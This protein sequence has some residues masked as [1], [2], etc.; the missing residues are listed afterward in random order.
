[1]RPI[2]LVLCGL[3]SA[4]WLLVAAVAHAQES[5][6]APRWT[7]WVT[8]DLGGGTL[9]AAPG[10][11]A[12]T[13]LATGLAAS[14]QWRQL[15]LRVRYMKLSELLGDRSSDW[16]VLA[17]IATL[18]GRFYAGAALGVGRATGDRAP[19][20]FGP[21]IA[22]GSRTTLP[23]EAELAW[24]PFG[25]LG[26]GATGFASLN[27]GFTFAGVAFAVELGRVR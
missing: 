20:A 6:T 15:L 14:A 13:K 12:S 7:W 19:D 1:L 4:G 21:Y 2:L 10:K 22:Q 24:R 5:A 26:V 17:G 9:E 8:G 11:Q 18:P 23:V 27:S 16:G 3:V 25:S